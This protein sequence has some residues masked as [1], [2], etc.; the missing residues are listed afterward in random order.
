MIF[1]HWLSSRLDLF[2]QN[3]TVCQNQIGSRLVLHNTI[4]CLWKNATESESGKLAAGQKLSLMIP[5]PAH[6]IA[7]RPDAFGQ[8]LTRPSRSD[9]VLHNMSH[10]FF[11]K[12]KLHQSDAGSWIKHFKYISDPA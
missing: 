12:V 4:G 10:A 5:A 8:T 1:A 3:L 2:G 9:L 7:S 6:Q 11:E